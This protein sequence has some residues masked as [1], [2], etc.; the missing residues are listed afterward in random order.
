MKVANMTEQV[1][2]HGL[3]T[4]CGWES[5]HKDRAEKSATELLT[6]RGWQ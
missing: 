4:R 3:T 2:T 6:V 1:T 5:K